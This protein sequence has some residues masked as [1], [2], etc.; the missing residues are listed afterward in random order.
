MSVLFD[1]RL[2]LA[3]DLTHLLGVVMIVGE[4]PVDICHIEIVAIGD[5]SWIEPSLLD[6]FSDELNGD[7]LPTL[8]TRFHSLV[9]G[10]ASCFHDALC[11]NR[12]GS[13]KER[14]LRRR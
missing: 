8:L 3:F 1:C 5:G 9:E 2:P 13:R 7:F 6:L 10:G 12:T 14:S 11:R 4:R